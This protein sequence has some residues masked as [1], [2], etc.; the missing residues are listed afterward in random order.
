MEGAIFI[1]ED[2]CPHM[3]L[4][5]KGLRDRQAEGRT[6]GP[7]V[8]QGWV[9]FSRGVIQVSERVVPKRTAKKKPLFPS[10]R[11]M[12]PLSPMPFA[13]ISPVVSGL[14]CGPK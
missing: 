9:M 12:S 1:W 10:C 14:Y 7:P 3:P 11:S 8:Q 5:K 6:V 2:S 13:P 4:G